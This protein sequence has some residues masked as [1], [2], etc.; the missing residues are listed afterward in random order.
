[1]GRVMN[2]RII[3]LEAIVEPKTHGISRAVSRP[4]KRF[5]ILYN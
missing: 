4:E 1:M 3:F 5:V 2:F